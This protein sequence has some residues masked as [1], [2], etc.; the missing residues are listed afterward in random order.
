MLSCWGLADAFQG[1]T[2][3]MARANHVTS[4]IPVVLAAPVP[5]L[6]LTCQVLQTPK[7]G[8][9]GQLVRLGVLDCTVGKVC[10]NCK[11]TFD[12]SGVQLTFQTLFLPSSHCCH[13]LVIHSSKALEPMLLC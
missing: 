3:E 4:H 10:D 5:S 11:E 12:R 13:D 7:M 8:S 1:S 6:P 2:R 9:R